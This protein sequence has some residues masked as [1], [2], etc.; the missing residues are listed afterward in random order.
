MSSKLTVHYSDPMYS[1]DHIRTSDIYVCR[2]CLV[3]FRYESFLSG[4]MVKVKV[5]I[6]DS[7]FVVCYDESIGK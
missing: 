4:E 3:H 2:S 6:E 1:S 7:G 5:K